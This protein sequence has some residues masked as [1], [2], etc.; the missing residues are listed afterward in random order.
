[1]MMVGDAVASASLTGKMT[2]E[3]CTI[4]YRIPVTKYFRYLARGLTFF[5]KCVLKSVRRG[6]AA[7]F[8]FIK[9]VRLRVRLNPELR[10]NPRERL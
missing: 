10:V 1:M 3:L 2:A 8:H 6:S 4:H 5:C 7:C 9:P